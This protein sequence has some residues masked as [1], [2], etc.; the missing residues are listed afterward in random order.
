MKGSSEHSEA[1]LEPPRVSEAVVLERRNGVG[2]NSLSLCGLPGQSTKK[3]TIEKSGKEVSH[4]PSYTHIHIHT[5][6]T[7]QVC[8]VSLTSPDTDYCW[9]P[10]KAGNRSV[11]QTSACYYGHTCHL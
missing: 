9:L 1:A 11:P 2:R 4:S 6:H 7:N 5:R 8:G 10:G 3:S